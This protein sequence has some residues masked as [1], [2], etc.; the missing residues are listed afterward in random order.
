MWSAA[1]KNYNTAYLHF[2]IMSP[3]PYFHFTGLYLSNHLRYL[4]D[5]LKD[6]RTGQRRVPHARMETLFSSFISPD[7][8]F[9]FMPLLGN[10]VFVEFPRFFFFFL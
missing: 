5:T 9:L 1:C 7:P 8:Y 10:L 4:N 6:F 2:L 3:G